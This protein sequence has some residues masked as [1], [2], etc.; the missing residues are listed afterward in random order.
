MNVVIS[1][2][3]LSFRLVY[4]IISFPFTYVCFPVIRFFYGFVNHLLL[5]PLLLILRTFIYGFIYIPLVPFLKATGVEYD[6]LVP[7]EVTLYRLAIGFAPHLNVFIYHFI[8]YFMVSMFVGSF[9]GMFAGL[10]ISIVARILCVSDVKKELNLKRVGDL[11]TATPDWKR[12]KWEPKT[13]HPSL[14]QKFIKDEGETKDPKKEDETPAVKIE[15]PDFLLPRVPEITEFSSEAIFEDDDGYNFMTYKISDDRRKQI[16][17]EN[18]KKRRENRYR[19]APPLLQVT[20]E[21]ES[22]SEITPTPTHATSAVFPTNHVSLDYATG[23]FGSSK[24]FSTESSV[25]SKNLGSSRSE[26]KDATS[27]ESEGEETDVSGYGTDTKDKKYTGPD[28]KEKARDAYKNSQEIAGADADADTTFTREDVP[29]Q[30]S[31]AKIYPAQ[32]LEK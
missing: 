26:R 1:A 27:P 8:H 4:L 12:V 20:I 11:S 22:E 6:T 24:T 2:I 5:I 25:F 32:T 13:A 31:K 16:K 3:Q 21:E 23:T 29:K 7:V 17:K 9:V 30:S 18:Y 19:N 28:A 10:N 15:N 14:T